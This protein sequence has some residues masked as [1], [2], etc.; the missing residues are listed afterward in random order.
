MH[1]GKTTKLLKSSLCFLTSDKILLMNHSSCKTGWKNAD[2][3]VMLTVWIVLKPQI[4][5]SFL[6]W[7]STHSTWSM[8]LRKLSFRFLVNLKKYW[9]WAHSSLR[10]SKSN[11]T[12]ISHSTDENTYI[13][14]K[15]N[16]KRFEKYRKS[17]DKSPSN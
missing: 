6:T 10:P 15:I 1:A 3:S 9:N 13:P 5:E 4:S 2:F 16:E 12:D 8:R 14:V 11:L 7:L 17:H